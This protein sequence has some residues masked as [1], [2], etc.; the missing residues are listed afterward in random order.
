MISS[1]DAA[2]M[3][4]R[5][6]ILRKSN[7]LS[8]LEKCISL[9]VAEQTGLHFHVCAVIV[10]EGFAPVEPI[11][12]TAP[13][14]DLFSR[15]LRIIREVDDSCVRVWM[16]NSHERLATAMYKPRHRPIGLIAD[17]A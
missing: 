2:Q 5:H 16:P 3:P 11:R 10:R 4:N 8:R 12:I 7:R 1:C 15:Q 13:G 17:Y 9:L 14:P 6:P